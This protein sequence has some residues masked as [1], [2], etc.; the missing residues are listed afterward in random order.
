MLKGRLLLAALFCLTMLNSLQASPACSPD[1]IETRH[2]TMPEDAIIWNSDDSPDG[3]L[4]LTVMVKSSVGEAIFQSA[5]ATL[6][7]KEKFLLGFPLLPQTVPSM[8]DVRMF[9]IIADKSQLDK[10]NLKLSY[11][12]QNNPCLI[13][14]YEAGYR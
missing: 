10:F 13:Y 11:Q 7:D 9:I 12:S 6:Y 2:D 4:G 5:D 1:S 3:I 14:S 8:Q